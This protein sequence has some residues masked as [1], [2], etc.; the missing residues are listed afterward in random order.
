M[1]ITKA[2]PLS[3]GSVGEIGGPLFPPSPGDGGGMR[4]NFSRVFRWYAWYVGDARNG[5]LVALA[6]THALCI[7]ASGRRPA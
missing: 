2:C 5:R 3:L 6:Q 4:G 7:R 1:T